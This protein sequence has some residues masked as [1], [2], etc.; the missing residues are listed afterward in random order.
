MAHAACKWV[1][2]NGVR[3]VA[4]ATN[5]RL[6]EFSADAVESM[7]DLD[8]AYLGAK[9]L[10]Q[11]GDEKTAALVAEFGAAVAARAATRAADRVG[12]LE[13]GKL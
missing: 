6:D 3:A 11:N 1:L 5:T 10:I 7:I 12:D 9:H 2:N 8:L 13:S 4:E